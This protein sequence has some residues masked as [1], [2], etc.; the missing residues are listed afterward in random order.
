[1]KDSNQKTAFAFMIIF[2]ILF[3]SIMCVPQFYGQDPNY[4][5]PHMGYGQQQITGGPQMGYEQQPMAGDY[6]VGPDG[7][8][9][10]AEVG[11]DGNTYAVDP[12]GRFFGLAA[13][14][15]GI[16]WSGIA[17]AI[18]TGTAAVVGAKAIKD[19]AE[20][21]TGYEGPMDSYHPQMGD[22]YHPQVGYPMESPMGSSMMGAP[23]MGNPY[24]Y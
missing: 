14:L 9:Y 13:L 16:T 6:G 8:I 19:M 20:G 3:N 15:A 12:D 2:N 5:S 1:M 4:G 21:K 17:K 10:H 23:M 11:A 7:R 22:S 24:G 18:A